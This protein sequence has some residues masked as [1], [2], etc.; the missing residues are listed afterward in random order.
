MGRA[1]GGRA[2]AALRIHEAEAARRRQGAPA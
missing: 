1:R 2:L